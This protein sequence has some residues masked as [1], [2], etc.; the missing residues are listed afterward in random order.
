MLPVHAEK[1]FNLYG[2]KFLAETRDTPPSRVSQSGSH[3]GLQHTT[4]YATVLLPLP[5]I[6]NDLEV[7]RLL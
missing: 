7:V 6:Y 1:P 5:G 4:D 3:I 2:S